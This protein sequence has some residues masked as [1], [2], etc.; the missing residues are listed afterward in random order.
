MG[1]GLRV[2]K[3]P[4]W[5]VIKFKWEVIALVSFALLS[6]NIRGQSFIL[7][8]SSGG[9]RPR[10]LSWVVWTSGQ[11][12]TW[13]QEAMLEWVHLP[14]K[15]EK[16]REEDRGRERERQ[17]ETDRERDRERDRETERDRENTRISP[18]NVPKY[19]LLDLLKVLA[20]S[21]STTLRSKPPIHELLENIQYPN[22]DRRWVLRM[23]C[24][25]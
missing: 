18:F 24:G 9:S 12:S 16:E 14:H 21:N 8:H 23:A 7:A 15:P 1:Q 11:S 13:C 19:V 2:V 6:W 20:P 4:P 3:R 22:H 10:S 17:R 5:V 25:T